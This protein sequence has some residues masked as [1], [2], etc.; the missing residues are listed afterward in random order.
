[1]FLYRAFPWLSSARPGE[2]GHPLYVPSPQGAGRADNPE[3]YLSLYLSSAPAGAVAE[4]F[5]NFPSWTPNIF[6]RPELPGLVRALGTYQLSEDARICDLDDAPTLGR[7]GLRPSDVVTRQKEITQRW[8]LRIFRE[9]Q[10]IGFRWWSYYD[11]RWYSYALWE[12]SRL[13]VER[14][15]PLALDHPAVVEAADV[16]RRPRAT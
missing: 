2:P 10:W 14:V 8:A 5:G 13:S 12:R 4:A 15:E 9:G 6:V 1:V 3:H 11:P 7:L 16:L